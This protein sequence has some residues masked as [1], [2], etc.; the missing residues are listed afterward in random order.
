MVDIFSDRLSFVPDKE[1]EALMDSIRKRTAVPDVRCLVFQLTLDVY[2]Q[3]ATRRIRLVEE[4]LHMQTIYLTS[5]ATNQPVSPIHVRRLYNRVNPPQPLIVFFIES[6][7]NDLLSGAAAATRLHATCV[8]YGIASTVR[9]L[10]A[11]SDVTPL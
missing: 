10:A 1:A 9:R 8:D 5:N 6:Q 7:H 11:K 2:D 3:D 4:A